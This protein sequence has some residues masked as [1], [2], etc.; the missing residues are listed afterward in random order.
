MGKIAFQSRLSYSLFNFL[1]LSFVSSFKIETIPH[2]GS[3]PMN[4]MYSSGIYDPSSS[5]FYI[6]GGFSQEKGVDTSDI[7][8]YSLISSKWSKIT[9]E[10][11]FI[12]GG[13][14][15]HFSYLSANRIIYT[16]FGL[17]SS[18]CITDLYTFDLSTFRWSSI[19]L[20]GDYI[21][22]RSLYSVTTFSWNN[23]EYIGVYG[24]Y[25]REVYDSNL[26]L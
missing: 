20:Q 16:F 10:S 4:L 24:G 14:Q 1:L 12:P 18:R 8:L 19:Q 6:I 26:Y 3:P 13:M 11:E 9:P 7:Y 15:Q 22:G 17:F 25:D 21:T 2:Q 5:T 23:T